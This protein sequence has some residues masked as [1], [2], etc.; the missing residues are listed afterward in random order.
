MQTSLDGFVARSSG[1]LDWLIWDWSDSLSWDEELQREFSSI[2]ASAGCVLL[3]GSMS[4][5]GYTDHWSGMADRHQDDPN[6][7]FAAHI[8][9]ADKFIVNHRSAALNRNK[10]ILAGN[11]ASDAIRK[12]KEQGGSDIISFGGA[13]FASWLLRTGLVDELHLFVNP[14]VL[15]EGLSI[16]KTSGINNL[17]IKSAKSYSCGIAVLKYIL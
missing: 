16:L 11:S 8:K 7:K 9:Q 15:G 1:S 12:F 13:R 6:F 3:S 4:E 14:V 2:I 5:E 17:L 10:S